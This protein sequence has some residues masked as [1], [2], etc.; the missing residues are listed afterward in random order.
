MINNDI[1]KIGAIAHNFTSDAVMPNGKIEKKFNLHDFLGKN[2]SYGL[3]FFYP[4]DFT[5][6]CPTELISFDKRI[7]DFEALNCK[8][9]GVSIDSVFVHSKWRET[10]IQDGGIGEIKYPLISDLNHKIMQKYG[11]VNEDA[12]VAYR[13][14]FIID[15]NLIIR[16]ISINDLNIGRN[17]DEYLRILNALQH[18]EK[19]GEVCPANWNKGDDAMTP[20]DEGLKHYCKSNGDNL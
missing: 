8:I 18:A 2:D 19:Y 11:V 1:A 20:T 14:T 3:I 12:S 17:V 9:I 15:K 4:L 13:G 6:V 16:H 10:S 7:N 5:F